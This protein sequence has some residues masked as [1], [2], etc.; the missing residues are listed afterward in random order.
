VGTTEKTKNWSKE[1]KA[2]KK[3]DKLRM[4]KQSEDIGNDADTDERATARRA[5]AGGRNCCSLFGGG[6][7]IVRVRIQRTSKARRK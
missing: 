3:I 1:I 2:R 4:T 6:L 5:E 7:A